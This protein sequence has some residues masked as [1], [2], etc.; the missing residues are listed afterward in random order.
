[1]INAKMNQHPNCQP[2]CRCS[3]EAREEFPEM[4]SLEKS[5]KEE[6][7]LIKLQ[8][9]QKL[10]NDSIWTQERSIC[11]RRV[12]VCRRRVKKG[13]GIPKIQPWGLPM[14]VSQP[15]G[16]METHLNRGMGS[17]KILP[18]GRQLQLRQPRG[19]TVQTS[20]KVNR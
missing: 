10:R 16:P 5:S 6:D 11:G 17:L 9:E 20:R 4:P 3:D 14:Q 7:E 12:K 2:G 19:P 13:L 1:M 8:R 15:R 18:R